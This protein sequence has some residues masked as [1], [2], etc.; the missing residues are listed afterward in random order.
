MDIYVYTVDKRI[1]IE[2]SPQF[3]YNLNGN[4]NCTTTSNKKKNNNKSYKLP[5]QENTKKDIAKSPNEIH[6]LFVSLSCQEAPWINVE[7]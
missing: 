7:N 2:R 5:K 3:K 6:D 1:H 4:R